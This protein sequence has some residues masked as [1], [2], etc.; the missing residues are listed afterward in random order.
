MRDVPVADPL[1]AYQ[2]APAPGAFVGFLTTINSVAG[3]ATVGPGWEWEPSTTGN[4]PTEAGSF[5]QVYPGGV[6]TLPASVPTTESTTPGVYS[7]WV[8]YPTQANGEPVLFQPVT[9][10]LYST[11]NPPPASGPMGTINGWQVAADNGSA[12]G[13]GYAVNDPYPTWLTWENTFP[14]LVWSGGSYGDGTPS[15][16]APSSSGS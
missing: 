6:I 10:G 12:T 8:L 4:G 16:A 5:V 3:T 13:P 14:N 2:S 15:F 11:A 9:V 1:N 7:I